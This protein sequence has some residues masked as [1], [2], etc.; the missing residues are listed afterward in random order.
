MSLSLRSIQRNF[1]FYQRLFP[2]PA[3]FPLKAFVNLFQLSIGRCLRT[4]CLFTASAVFKG[5][6]IAFG[7]CG[8][9]VRRP[10]SSS[11]VRL[12]F[13]FFFF[14][15][16]ASF[17]LPKRGDQLGEFGLSCVRRV[18]FRFLLP[19][20]RALYW[21]RRPRELKLHSV[22][23]SPPPPPPLPLL[24]PSPPPSFRGSFIHRTRFFRSF[25]R[26]YR[27]VQLATVLLCPYP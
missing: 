21:R 3:S 15:S 27:G 22:F 8:P 25:P 20:L 2:S 6:P 5:S 9:G 14:Q 11:L 26:V 18:G 23:L 7:A 13:S 4:S 1:S 16:S 12:S 10:S 17:P 19:G 24:S